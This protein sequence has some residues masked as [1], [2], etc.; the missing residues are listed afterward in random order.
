MSGFSSEG[1][2]GGSGS[3]GPKG[4][5][6]NNGAQGPQG[7]RG[8]TGPAGSQGITPTDP[9]AD[10]STTGATAFYSEAAVTTITSSLDP[11][12]TNI[13]YDR[14]HNI[15]HE[16]V[17]K[18]VPTILYPG[19][20]QQKS[21]FSTTVKRRIAN[22]VGTDGYAPLVIAVNSRGRG[23]TSGTIDYV[24]DTQDRFDALEHAASAV[25]SNVFGGGRSAIL[26][27]YST[28][29]LDA[30]LAAC[31]CPDRVLGIVLYY[32]NYDLGVDPLDSYWAMQTSAIRANLI[33]QIGDR[34][35]GSTEALDPYLARNPIDAITR[36]IAAPGG[37]HIW[38]LGDRTE[39]PIVPI[40]NPDRLAAI[41]QSIPE[42]KDKTH[43]QITQSDSS[44][45]ILHNLDAGLVSG[46][47]LYAERYFW[48]TLL[49]NVAEWSL[50]RESPA[51]GFRLL[52]W[53]KTRTISGSTNPIED[54]SGFEIWTGTASSP[55]SDADGGKLHVCEMNYFDT[56]RQFIFDPITSQNGYLEVIKDSDDRKI[57]LTANTRSI[58]NL[59]ASRTITSMTDLG[60]T[61]EFRS[62]LGV[63]GTTTVTNWVDQIGALAFTASANHPA[64][65]TDSDNKTLIRF[66]SASSQKLTCTSLLED[67]TADFTIFM[68]VN[69]SNTTAQWFL[70]M[71]HHGSLAEISLRYA[72]TVDV[73]DYINDSGTHGAGING[74]GGHVIST[75][76]KHFLVLMRKNGLYRISLDGSYWS[77]ATITDSTF[78]ITGTNTTTLG[79]G[80]A[81]S[82]GVYWKFLD[83]DIYE[84]ASRNAA[85]SEADVLSAYALMKSR[86]TF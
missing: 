54:R 2:G 45:R 16:A 40:P 62:D 9:T 76:A 1:T 46:G 17:G 19:F 78:T 35:T 38:I 49:N 23:S 79:A 51:G 13:S 69:K 20:G 81:N 86:W 30:L 12:I 85:T 64:T 37:P 25:G 29:C 77:N 61:H 32:P 31:R 83:G 84:I 10:I 75:N 74:I 59:N 52:G 4:D 43:V 66:V 56:G 53:M 8:P 47:T 7:I 36:I 33:S 24:R 6:G 39:S 27:G 82:A 71:S 80:W 63:T 48:P 28:G 34:G 14:C 67:P 21:Q 73:A 18:L 44:N 22:Y 65:A 3:Q 26:I 55:K 60:C 41:L 68:V 70:A 57:S 5:P 11:S 42:A 58:V 72:S 15:G 50:P